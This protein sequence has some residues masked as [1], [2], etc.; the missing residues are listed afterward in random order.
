[1]LNSLFYLTS[2]CKLLDKTILLFV[3]SIKYGHY[4]Y[5]LYKQT[6]MLFVPVSPFHCWVSVLVYG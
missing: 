5:I 3:S 4:V 2:V 1:M 6:Q